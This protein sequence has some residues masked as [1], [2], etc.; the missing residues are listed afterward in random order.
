MERAK[1]R[2]EKQFDTYM[3][4]LKEGMSEVRR[5]QKDAIEKAVEAHCNQVISHINDFGRNVSKETIQEKV[6][7][8]LELIKFRII[9]RQLEKLKEDKKRSIAEISEEHVRKIERTIEKYMDVD[10]DHLIPKLRELCEVGKVDSFIDDPEIAEE[11]E[12]NGF[13]LNPILEI[14]LSPILGYGLL[15]GAAFNAIRGNGEIKQKIKD[16][17]SQYRN[18][19]TADQLV[20]GSTDIEPIRDRVK[21]L[22]FDDFIDPIDKDLKQ[23]IENRE[24]R[25]KQRADAAAKLEALQKQKQEY[26]AKVAAMAL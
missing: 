11:D 20:E 13:D 9:P 17:I 12:S 3:I 23:I 21:K 7:Q 25:E 5:R 18:N 8:E 2:L 24:G 10:T 15:F 6:G 14:L 4:E 22:M 19:F 1:K 16:K 26:D